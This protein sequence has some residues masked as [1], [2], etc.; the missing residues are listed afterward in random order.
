[1]KFLKNHRFLFVLMAAAFANHAASQEAKP[2]LLMDVVY[3]LR[4]NAFPYVSVFTKTKIEKKFTA[5]AG[6]TVKVYLGEEADANLMG[7]A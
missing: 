5:V 4:D 6:I 7:T 3:H 1:M 2:K